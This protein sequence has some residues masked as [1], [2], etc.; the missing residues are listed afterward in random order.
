MLDVSPHNPAHYCYSP[1]AFSTFLDVGP[2]QS[3][4]VNALKNRHRVKLRGAQIRFEDD[5][6]QL[7]NLLERKGAVVNVN[8][9]QTFTLRLVRQ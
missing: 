4:A 3:K 1:S 9:R 6:Q 8:S 5:P 7:N 2:K